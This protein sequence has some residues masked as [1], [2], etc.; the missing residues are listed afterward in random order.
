MLQSWVII[1][2]AL[3]DLFLTKVGATSWRE[4]LGAI[5]ARRLTRS[6]TALLLGGLIALAFILLRQLGRK[7]SDHPRIVLLSPGAKLPYYFEDVYLARL[8]HGAR[9]PAQAK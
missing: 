5:V 9:P 4:A 3:I 7:H 2:V 8:R 1:A 6:W